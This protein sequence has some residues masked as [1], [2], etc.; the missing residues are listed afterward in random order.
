MTFH[1]PI[2][3]A[4]VGAALLLFGQ[5]GAAHAAC[6]S[7]A[8][9]AAFDKE[10]PR[11]GR[12]D[13]SLLGTGVLIETNRARCAQGLSPLETNRDLQKAAQ[14]HSADM[15]KRNFFDHTSP[16]RGRRTLGDR[17]SK[18]GY[19]FRQ[20]AENIIESH[21]VAY[22]SGARYRVTDEKRCAFQYIDGRTIARHTY[23]SLA[24]EVVTRWMDSPGHRRN[25]LTRDL[26]HHGF[27]MAA[28]KDQALCG[29]IYATQVMGR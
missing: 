4:L 12:H 10:L 7:G 27:A 3:A 14:W 21:F 22:E 20:I 16:V 1:K 24:R 28:N 29:G 18:A 17:V 2:C 8:L 5:G 6:P 25:I 13:A 15:A 11:N 23:G 19:N 9:P 26:R